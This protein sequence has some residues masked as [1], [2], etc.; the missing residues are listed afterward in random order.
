MGLKDLQIEDRKP[1]VK[2]HV[3]VGTLRLEA[4]AQPDPDG[5]VV[6]PDLGGDQRLAQQRV[7]ERRAGVAAVVG[8]LAAHHVGRHLE[9]GPADLPAR[10][11]AGE[12]PRLEERPQ[13]IAES[14]HRA[15]VPTARR[16]RRQPKW[17]DL[18]SRRS[19]DPRAR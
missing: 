10:R 9:L 17:R 7:A 4:D 18:A 11:R 1:A 14:L 8:R 6:E 3:Q 2:G 15:I 13:S 12:Q 5:E 16:A 19:P